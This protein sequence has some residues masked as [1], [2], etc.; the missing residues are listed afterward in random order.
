MFGFAGICAT[1]TRDDGVVVESCA[2]ITM[3][4]NDFM[5]AI[6]NSKKR[7]PLV[8]RVE[9]R[10]AWLTG[11]TETAASILQRPDESWQAHQVS[12]NVNSPTNNHAG[13]IEQ[14]P[15]LL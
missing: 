15:D 1:S 2:I 13:L 4:A 9:D 14:Q 5:A 11:D 3:P 8:V 7:Q 6:H 12:K 10:E